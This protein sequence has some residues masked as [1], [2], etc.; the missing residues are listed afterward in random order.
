MYD[1]RSAYFLAAAAPGSLLHPRLSDSLASVGVEL[2]TSKAGFADVFFWSNGQPVVAMRENLLDGSRQTLKIQPSL[3]PDLANAFGSVVAFF[4]EGK[5]QAAAIA[6]EIAR[7]SEPLAGSVQIF[8]DQYLSTGGQM[9]E[10]LTG[11]DRF[12]A[13]LRPFL[14]PGGCTQDGLC[15]H[16]YDLALAPLAKAA[17]VILCTPEGDILDPPF[18][19]DL[20]VAWCGYANDTIRQKV[21]PIIARSVRRLAASQLGCKL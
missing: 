6:E 17:G 3:S 4:P 9:I 15:C 11:H 5:R 7:D 8:D 18:G 12:I 14:L 20:D 19:L 21:E 2:P 13:D 10:L 16:P 1:K